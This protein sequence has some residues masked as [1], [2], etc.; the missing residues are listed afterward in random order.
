MRVVLDTNTVISGLL[1]QGPPRQIL[2][3]VRE[4]KI[5]LFA[6][7]AMLAELSDVLQRKKFATRLN[8]AGVTVAELMRG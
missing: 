3:L 7:S 2:S 1:W 5:T 8:A 4:G 6:S